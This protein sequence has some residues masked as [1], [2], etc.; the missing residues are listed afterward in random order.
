MA[1]QLESVVPWGRN[2]NEYMLMF[3]LSKED[4]S[5]KIAGFGDGPASFNYEATK[6]GYT[7]TSFDPIYQFSKKQL[8]QRIQEV[9]AIVMQQMQENINNY[10]W[11][12]IKNLEELETIGMSA[13]QLFLEDYEC[14]KLEHRYICHT[15]PEQLPY[16]NNIFVLCLI[17]IR[18]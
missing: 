13:M 18:R 2:L 15:L 14:G 1:F 5:K 6:K 16:E 12:N 3:N 8:Q 9:R 4:L 11:T 7:I 10:I 17:H